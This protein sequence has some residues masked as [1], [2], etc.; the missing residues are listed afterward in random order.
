MSSISRAYQDELLK[1]LAD[2]FEAIA[3]LNAA[4]DDGSNELFLLALQNVIKAQYLRKSD[5]VKGLDL[6]NLQLANLGSILNRL[7]FRFA[8][9]VKQSISIPA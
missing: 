3:Y 5:E 4:L 6:E 2:P 9:E 8:S 7:G 1:A